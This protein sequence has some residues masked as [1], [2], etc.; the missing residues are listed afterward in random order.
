[1]Y[2]PGCGAEIKEDSL[3]CP[4]C[5]AKI[6]QQKGTVLQKIEETR[7]EERYGWLAMIIGA[8]FMIGAFIVAAPTATK[9]VG[10]YLV[11][12]HPNAD[13]GWRLVILGAISVSIGAGVCIY[14]S[15]RRNRLLRQYET[16]EKQDRG[17]ESE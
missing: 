15:R 10:D 3:Y 16:Q 4:Q 14:C 7:H 13:T 2:C 9:T 5:G 12:Y 11:T 8:I 17:A 6:G 1:M